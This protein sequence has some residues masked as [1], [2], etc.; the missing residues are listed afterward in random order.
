[1][2]SG[3]ARCIKT[4]SRNTLIDRFDSDSFN[5]YS[6][7]D[8][9]GLEQS[10]CRLTHRKFDIMGWGSAAVASACWP[11]SGSTSTR[12]RVFTF[13]FACCV[14]REWKKAWQLCLG[15]LPQNV[16]KRGPR[17]HR[18][19]ITIAL[20]TEKQIVASIINV[21]VCME[22]S[23]APNEICPPPTHIPHPL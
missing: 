7:W 16:T 23:T 3:E 15:Y 17:M 5:I 13:A 4:W 11:P 14:G 18:R 1:M 19:K 6:W 22:F 12:K 20:H 9:Q 10:S 21:Q 2:R 8:V